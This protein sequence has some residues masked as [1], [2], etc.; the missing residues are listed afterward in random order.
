MNALKFGPLN[1]QVS[2]LRSKYEEI[3]QKKKFSVV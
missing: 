2:H 3:A 1:K